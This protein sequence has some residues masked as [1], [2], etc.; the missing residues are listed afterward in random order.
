MKGKIDEF[1]I[2]DEVLNAGQIQSLFDAA[3]GIPNSPPVAV[4]DNATTSENTPVTIGNVLLNDSDADGD[5]LSVTS[6][7]M[8]SVH[9]G[10]ITHNGDGTF[11]VMCD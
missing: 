10:S 3:N 6:F 5:A 8:V 9:G 1:A 4:D 7:D 11:T 2:F